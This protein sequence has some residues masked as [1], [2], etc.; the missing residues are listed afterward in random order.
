MRNAKTIGGIT[1]FQTRKNAVYRWVKGRASQTKF[2][3][4]LKEI[5]GAQRTSY[6]P[7]KCLKPSEII[8]SDVIVE[9]IID[10]MQSHFVEPFDLSLDKERLYNIVSGKPVPENVKESLS[11]I[12]STG[13]KYFKNFEDRLGENCYKAFHD[14]ITC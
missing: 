2:V 7:K 14:T 5:S 3:D 6:N 8:K 12:R 10:T 11:S 1:N 9:R 4:A 13:K